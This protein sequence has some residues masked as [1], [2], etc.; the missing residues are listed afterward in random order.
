MLFFVPRFDKLFSKRIGHFCPALLPLLSGVAWPSVFR[1][2]Q[3]L[4][5]YF[6]LIVMKTLS[7]GWATSERYHD[8]FANSCIFGCDGCDGLGHYLRCSRLWRPVRDAVGGQDDV[9]ES[10]SSD[11]TVLRRLVLDSAQ[12][13]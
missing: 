6:S 13:L 4:S 3:S 2:F 1:S 11:A 10:E 12:R 7:N 5:S 8:N 9:M